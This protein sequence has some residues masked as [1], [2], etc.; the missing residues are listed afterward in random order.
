MD[1]RTLNRRDVLALIENQFAIPADTIVGA[2]KLSSF[3]A[4]SLDFQ[5]LLISLECDLD[6]AIDDSDLNEHCTVD[7]LVAA[8]EKA[9]TA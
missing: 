4:D 7:E 1:P 9:R 8:V 6:V 5:S 2:E 3:G